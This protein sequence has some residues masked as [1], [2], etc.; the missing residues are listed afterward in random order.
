MAIRASFRLLLAISAG[1]FTPIAISP[2][3]AQSQSPTPEF[4]EASVPLPSNEEFSRL[5]PSL[6][7]KTDEPS[8][9]EDSTVWVP[10]DFDPW[11][12]AFAESSRLQGQAFRV[13]KV[14]TYPVSMN[15]QVKYFLDRFT[16]ARRDVVGLWVRRSGQYLG[17][18]DLGS[19]S[20][21]DLRPW[22]FPYEPTVQETVSAGVDLVSFSGD[23]LLG[24]P[25]A[26]IVVG[27]RGIVSRLKKNPCSD[28]WP[29]AST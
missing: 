21:V 3:C 23:K 12:Y 19:G 25:Q 10:S 24:G 26:G 4:F 7:L 29:K 15:S 6:D 5:T 13:V 14:P 18:E 28:S 1:I 22:G 9:R 27:K 2:A 20:L 11:A 17:M 16:T 8:A